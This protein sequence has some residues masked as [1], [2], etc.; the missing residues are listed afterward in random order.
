MLHLTL[1]PGTAW[2]LPLSRTELAL[3]FDAMLAALGL[4]EYGVELT[5]CDD[6]GMEPVNREYLGCTG[7]TNILSFPE[8]DNGPCTAWDNA[9]GMT[10]DASCLRDACAGHDTGI[11]YTRGTASH[12][13]DSPLILGSLLLSVDTLRREAF[14][15]GQDET[16]HCVRLLAHGLAHIAG[17]DHGPE[18]DDVEN[19]AQDAALLAL[20]AHG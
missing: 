16:E 13:E 15:Y 3:V 11:D 17:Y 20:A 5:I 10:E 9:S 19:A 14:L 2:K 7:P 18:M 4:D 6:G 8:E 12:G 1:D